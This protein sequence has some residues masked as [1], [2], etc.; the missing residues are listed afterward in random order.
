M[1]TV[2]NSKCLVQQ[3]EYTSD[4]QSRFFKHKIIIKS[5]TRFRFCDKNLQ[6]MQSIFFS[7]RVKQTTRFK[8]QLHIWNESRWLP[9]DKGKHTRM[10]FLSRVTELWRCTPKA[11]L[12]G[13]LPAWRNDAVNRCLADGEWIVNHECSNNM[14]NHKCSNNLM[15]HECSDSHMNYECSPGQSNESRM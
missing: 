14:M 7:S 12:S 11:S 8:S 5:C 13:T 15:N 3:T 6:P 10:W 9:S 4:T 2:N 1:W